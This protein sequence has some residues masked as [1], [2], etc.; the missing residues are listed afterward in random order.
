MPQRPARL[1][2]YSVFAAMLASAGLPIYIHAPKFYLDEYGLGL[3]ALAGVLFVLRLFDLVQDPILGWLAQVART[4]RRPM[5]GGA[6]LLLG[7][8]MIG[9]FAVT[10]PIAPIWWF[11]LTLT[12]LF[13]SFSFLTICFYA[14]GVQTAAGLGKDGHFRLAA[15]RETGALIGVCVASVAPVALAFTGYPFAAFALGFAVLCG[16]GWWLMRAEWGQGDIG[17]SGGFGVVLRDFVALRLLLIALVNAAPVAVSSTLFLFYVESVLGAAGWE[18]PLLLLF[19]L[20]AAASAPLWSKVAARFGARPTLLGAMAS[21]ILSFGYVLTLGAGDTAA[22]ALVCLISGMALGAD[23]TLLPAIF[24]R[25]MAQIAPQA[26]EAFGLWNFVSKFTLAFAAVTLL[27]AL[28]AVGF[29]A[30][31][32]NTDEALNRLTYLYALVPCLL[33]LVAIALLIATPL[34][35]NRGEALD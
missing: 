5:V 19:F 16:F 35:E 28:D 15:W 6:V 25:R 21:A 13:S 27:P 1:A 8:S 23:L 33:K 22:F 32:T 20:A 11:A 34:P 9:L 12:G 18:G 10:P 7:A 4:W 17:A 31:G 3:T 29:E 2:G 30:G 26:S 14:E 24:A